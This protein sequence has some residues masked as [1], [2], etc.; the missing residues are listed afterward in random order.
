[1]PILHIIELLNLPSS[2]K[3]NKANVRNLLITIVIKLFPMTQHVVIA[4]VT[5]FFDSVAIP[6]KTLILL[7]VEET[8][9]FWV[10][11]ASVSSDISMQHEL[12]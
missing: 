12:A 11:S 9:F 10:S 8:D 6:N 1:M 3:E 5:P 2:Y 7:A 4:T